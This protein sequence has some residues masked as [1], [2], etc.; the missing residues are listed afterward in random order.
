MGDL[1][2]LGGSSFYLALDS[3]L[4][5]PEIDWDKS[6]DSG[7]VIS[8]KDKEFVHIVVLD[9]ENRIVD[10][11]Q[12]IPSKKEEKSS[13]S[14]TKL[15][16]S[17]EENDL[18]SS[19]E[20][21][22]SSLESESSSS[23]IESSSSEENISSSDEQSSSSEEQ[24][25]SS[26]VEESSSSIVESSSEMES[27]SS[28]VKLI[29]ISE[30]S[31][32]N[33]TISIEDSKIYVEVPYGSDLSKIQLNPIDSTNDLRRS[34]ELTFADDSGVEKVYNVVAGVQLPGSDFNQRN[35]FWATTSDAMATSKTAYLITIESSENAEFANSKLTLTTREVTGALGIATGSW[36]MAGGFYF[37]GSYFGNNAL[38]IYQEDY[39][40]GT[41]SESKASDISNDMTF[42]K[43]FSARPKSF[44]V[45]FAYNHVNN[46]NS[47]YPQQGLI[48]V[49]LISANNKVVASAIKTM[50]ET[51]DM[52][53]ETVSLNYGSDSGILESSYPI[54]SG[55]SVGNGSE[56]VATIYVMFASSAYAYIVDGGIA[57]KSGKYRGGENSELVID[58]FKL[59]Y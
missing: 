20:K 36:K 13:S 59:N 45:T 55:L 47:E 48:C 27:S 8:V 24:L 3:D 39:T 25:F 49:M 38:D 16:S 15:S 52:S 12:V 28:S 44:D 50:T 5:N 41:P 29:D 56:D 34:V 11:W 23:E 35:D 46:K 6:L 30:L 26:S 14:K 33:G 7:T 54:P 10:V 1:S 57:G 51:K 32:E 4:E 9:D 53:K 40:S 37:V 43:S 2:S 42:G 22:S 58:E 31:V 19:E 21:S 18:S 17:S